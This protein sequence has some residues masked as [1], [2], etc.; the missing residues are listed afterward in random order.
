MASIS[1]SLPLV[2]SLPGFK[3]KHNQNNKN[4]SLKYHL[5]I[6][7]IKSP[8][9]FDLNHSSPKVFLSKIR[10]SRWWFFCVCAKSYSSV[11]FFYSCFLKRLVLRAGYCLPVM[12]V[13]RIMCETAQTKEKHAR[14]PLRKRMHSQTFCL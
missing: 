3:K 6:M 2:Y 11:I 12:Y 13:Y 7:S 14:L 10:S 9:C 8:F 4:Q 5:F 1:S